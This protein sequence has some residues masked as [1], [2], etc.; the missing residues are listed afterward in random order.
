MIRK[1]YNPSLKVNCWEEQEAI[2]QLLRS[3][4]FECDLVQTT[5]FHH[6]LFS[7]LSPGDPEIHL[8]K[9]SGR[10][11]VRRKTN[12][13]VYGTFDDFP[14]FPHPPP[15]IDTCTIFLFMS[16][17]KFKELLSSRFCL[18]FPLPSFSFSLKSCIKICEVFGRFFFPS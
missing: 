14:C 12:G 4:A 9:S 11:N 10:E 17:I 1:R 7:K 16:R 6:L 5:V 18:C 15:S 13:L 2:N 8:H 3:R